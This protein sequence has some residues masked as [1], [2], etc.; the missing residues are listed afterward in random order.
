MDEEDFGMD[1]N[2]DISA[3]ISAAKWD[4]LPKKSRQRYMEVSNWSESVCEFFWQITLLVINKLSS[5]LK[6]TF[7]TVKEYWTFATVYSGESSHFR[8]GYG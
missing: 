4:T 5:P 6:S 8:H 3:H 2:E 1:E 7:V